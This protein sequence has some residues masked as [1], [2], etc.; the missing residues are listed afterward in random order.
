[1]A[2]LL[3]EVLRRGFYGSARVETGGQRRDDPIAAADD[4]ADRAG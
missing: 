2:E 1:M 3:Q 4:R